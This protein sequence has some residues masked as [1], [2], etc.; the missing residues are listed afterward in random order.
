MSSGFLYNVHTCRHANNLSAIDKCCEQNTENPHIMRQNSVSSAY[1]LCVV[2]CPDAPPLKQSPLMIVA[3]TVC[4]QYRR[5]AW[6][7]AQDGS[8]P[9]T[10]REPRCSFSIK[11]ITYETESIVCFCCKCLRKLCNLLR[12]TATQ[13]SNFFLVI[14]CQKRMK[15]IRAIVSRE[16]F[17]YSP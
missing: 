15:A 17:S 3:R 9:H 13:G 11:S 14:T 1:K 5:G 12:N 2:I 8:N 4:T 6:T 7:R 16:S 10:V